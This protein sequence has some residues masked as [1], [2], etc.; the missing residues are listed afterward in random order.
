[1]NDLRFALRQWCKSPGLA[2]V[3]VASLAVGI[4]ANTV[5][6]TLIRATLLNAIP[7]AGAPAELAV[8]MPEHKTGGLSDTMSLL[9]LES[10]ATEAGTFAGITASQFGVVQVRQGEVTEWLWGQSTLANFF[11]VLQVRPALGRGFLPGEDRPGAAQ[12]V[13]VISHALWQRRFHGAPDVLGRVLEID[14]RPVTIIGVAPAGFVGTMGGLRLDLWVPLGTQFTDD[15]LRP[16]YTA[17]N[18]RWLHTVARLAPGVRHREADTV[19]GAISQRLAREFPDTSRDTTLRVIRVW[20][21]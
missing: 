17:R 1:M 18:S 4:G 5:V 12:H 21:S 16:R 3:I 2:L 20:E 19:A 10:L 8:V 13:A 14:R 15:D 11:E 6:F 7:G 9:D